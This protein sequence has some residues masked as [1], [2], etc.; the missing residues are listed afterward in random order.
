MRDHLD[1]MSTRASQWV[2]SW[3]VVM[4]NQYGND[5]TS[6]GHQVREM[7]ATF[8][9]FLHDGEFEIPTRGW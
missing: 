3:L 7:I 2:E 5:Q 8:F 4:Q 9:N 6:L 1:T